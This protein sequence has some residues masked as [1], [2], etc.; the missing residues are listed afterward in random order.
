MFLSS[1]E[2]YRTLR[3]RGRAISSTADCLIAACVIGEGA[4]LLENDRDFQKIAEFFPLRLVL[5]S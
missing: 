5:D 4:S 1:T 2:I 3:K